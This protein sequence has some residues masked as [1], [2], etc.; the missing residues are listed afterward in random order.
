MRPWR[1]TLLAF[2]C[3]YPYPHGDNAEWCATHT[4]DWTPL[5]FTT[6][7][8]HEGELRVA[9]ARL[10]A[11]TGADFAVDRYGVPVSFVPSVADAV[12]VPI[13]GHLCGGTEIAWRTDSGE[14]ISLDIF[15]AASP[16][17]C[18]DTVGLIVHEAIH[19]QCPFAQTHSIDG[20]FA[21][22]SNADMRLRGESLDIL[23]SCI[24]GCPARVDER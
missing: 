19:A 10:R 24:G 5:A 2:T 4:C 3:C 20:V 18:P 15:I 11:A 7:S 17:N 14:T 13:H 12:S 8:E 9:V 21:A 22:N 6:D 1:I 23:C 16:T